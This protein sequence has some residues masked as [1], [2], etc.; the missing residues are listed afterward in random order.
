MITSDAK[1]KGMSSG[2]NCAS[3]LVNDD[4]DIYGIALEAIVVGFSCRVISLDWIKHKF[5]CEMVI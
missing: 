5:Q 3:D 4:V 2:G 1:R